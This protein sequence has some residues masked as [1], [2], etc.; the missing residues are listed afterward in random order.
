MNSLEHSGQRSLGFFVDL[1]SLKTPE[2]EKSITA[3][4][5][6]RPRTA[7]SD[8]MKKSTG[9]YIDLSDDGSEST[10]SATPKLGGSKLDTPPPSASA[11]TGS[12]RGESED[13]QTDRKN[14]FSMFIDFGGDNANNKP[15]MPR[16]LSMPQSVLPGTSNGKESVRPSSLGPTMGEES[17]KPYYMFIGSQP[18]SQPMASVMRRPNGNAA[19][20]TAARHESKR[21]SW[22]TTVG[23]GG[24]IAGNFHERRIA[25]SSAYQRSTSVTSDRGIMN[26]LDKIPLLSKTSSMSIDSSVSPFEDFTCSKSELS[27]YSNHSIS[28]NSAHSSN[29][30]KVSPKDGAQEG[31]PMEM[32]AD[33]MMVSSTKKKRKDAKINETFDKSSHGSITDGILSSNEDASPTSTTTDTDDVTFQNNPAEEDALLTLQQPQ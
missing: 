27:T 4:V 18:D 13:R 6:S 9:F 19:G 33:G 2:E 21:H 28:S 17:S 11:L 31:Q 32:P 22:N 30:S 23:E 24:G 14:M 5:N 26:I 29:E 10:R 25:T 16:K 7:R 3:A 20:G 12:S 1:G 15:A 8:L